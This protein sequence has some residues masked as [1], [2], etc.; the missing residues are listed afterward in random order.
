MAAEQSISSG[1]AARYATALF[2][3]AKETNAVSTVLADLGRFDDLVAANPDMT[4]FVMSPVFSADEQLRA[5]EAGMRIDAA[6]VDDV[7]LGV[8]APHDLERARAVI[9]ARQKPH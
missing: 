9:A 6:L 1:F 4:R 3:L 8:D 5:L 2:E 7:P